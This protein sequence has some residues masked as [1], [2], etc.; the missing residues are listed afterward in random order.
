MFKVKI[1]ILCYRTASSITSNRQC[2]PTSENAT[3]ETREPL[4]C[5]THSENMGNQTSRIHFLVLP[6]Y[7]L[8]L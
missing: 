5:V 4:V 8:S 2:F 6:D 1:C 3:R 7:F